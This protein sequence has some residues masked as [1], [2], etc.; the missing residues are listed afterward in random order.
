VLI[1]SK[2]Q[3]RVLSTWC[4]S[5][6]VVSGFADFQND[7]TVIER[8]TTAFALHNKPQKCRADHIDLRKSRFQVR[9]D[10]NRD[11]SFSVRLKPC[12]VETAVS[13]DLD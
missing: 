2:K 12:F 1:D 11:F 6:E 8:F 3:A 10:E 9:G 13:G 4:K 5:I 7:A